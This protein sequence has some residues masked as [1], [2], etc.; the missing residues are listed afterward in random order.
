MGSTPKGSAYDT[1]PGVMRCRPSSSGTHLEGASSNSR[2]GVLAHRGGFETFGWTGVG[3]WYDSDADHVGAASNLK[4]TPA[5]FGKRRP[6]RMPPAYPG[7]GHLARTRRW[8][9]GKVADCGLDSL[10]HPSIG[11]RQPCRDRKLVRVRTSPTPGRTATWHRSRGRP[12]DQP[13]RRITPEARA[14]GRDGARAPGPA[15]P[16]TRPRRWNASVLPWLDSDM[17]GRHS[18]PRAGRSRDCPLCASPAAE[19]RLGL[20]LPT[21]LGWPRLL[22]HRCARHGLLRNMRPATTQRLWDRA[23][24]R[25][26]HVRPA[27]ADCPPGPSTSPDQGLDPQVSGTQQ[28][29]LGNGLDHTWTEELT[30]N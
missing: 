27:R 9:E 30:V 17:D 3:R 28:Q 11:R 24:I 4:S 8:L 15:R 16:T 6:T 20:D 23:R 29:T 26:S 19:T 10:S 21:G 7:L 1:P 2:R 25:V 5:A 22:G 13:G 12:Q 18:A 14:P